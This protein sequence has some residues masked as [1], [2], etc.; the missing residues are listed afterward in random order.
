MFD[1]ESIE[2]FMCKVRGEINYLPL[3]K[4]LSQKYPKSPAQREANKIPTF[5]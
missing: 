5:A 1:K 4:N 3:E 2:F